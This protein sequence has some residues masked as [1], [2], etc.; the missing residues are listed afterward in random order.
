M[1]PVFGPVL[2]LALAAVA[3]PAFAADVEL[4]SRIERV[5]VFPD[6]A[7]VQRSA[8]VDLAAGVSTLVLR[9]LPASLDPGSIR[10]EG[11]GSAGFAIGSVDVRAVPGEAQPAVNPELEGKIRALRD[12]RGAVDGRIAASEGKKAVIERY[13]QA[14]PEKLGVEAK[15]LEVSQWAAAF[16][17]IGG[18]LTAVHEELR[19]SRARARDL[20]AE[21]AA[22]ERARPAPLRPGAPKRDVIIAVEAGAALTGTLAVSYRVAGASWSPVYD[23]RLDTGGPDRKPALDWTRR[24]QVS[25]RTGE[26]WSDVQLAVST[27]R[28]NRGT[29]A[30]DLPPLQVSFYEP[31]VPM[32]APMVRRSEP[33]QGFDKNADALSAAEAAPQA[34]VP[35]TETVAAVEANAYQA[36]F[37]VPGRVGVTADGATKTF[38]LAQRRV[39]PS[40]A[41]RT[42][43]ELDPTAYLEAAF[44]NEEDAPLLAGEVLLHRDGTF[45]GRGRVKLTPGGDLV[46]LGFGA[47]DR[48]KVARVPLRRRE[49]EPGWIGQTK[50]DLREFKTTV[51]SLHAQPIRVTVMDRLP[52]TETTGIAVELMK[53]TTPPTERQLGDKRGVMAWAFDLAPSETK[54][55][56]LAYRL[57]WPAD[58]EVTF[59]PKPLPGPGR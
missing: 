36:T 58:R 25:Q 2:A 48:I 24:A 42:T 45:V 47:D 35:A 21:I 44:V 27:V 5:T 50:T 26:D 3:A 33:R 37:T 31:V 9:G 53:D 6:A 55:I 15:P 49:N 20:D 39:A 29:A 19:L 12:E 10:V 46:E 56:R 23:A 22:L 43:P 17:A 54:E 28:L 59:E 18:A 52:F 8:K 13:A 32:P 34:P 16:D 30:P 7:L 11:Q 38:A 4:A 40:L 51:R 57:R 14:S 1:R 41:A